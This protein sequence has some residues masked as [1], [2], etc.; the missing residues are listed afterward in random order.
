MML[1]D[2]EELLECPL[3]C[4]KSEDP[5]SLPCQ[6]FYCTKCLT[7]LIET[8]QFPNRFN[9]PNCRIEVQIPPGKAR[10]F[11]AAFMIN[12]LRKAVSKRIKAVKEGRQRCSEH[13]KELDLYCNKCHENI[14]SKCILDIQ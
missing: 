1:D 13:G 12:K 9:C 10:D 7:R 5:R 11:P 4:E 2:F 8:S 3:C 14:C 6:H